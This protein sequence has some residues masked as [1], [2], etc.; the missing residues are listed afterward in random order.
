MAEAPK[1]AKRLVPSPKPNLSSLGG[2]SDF[3]D[4]L[5]IDACVEMVRRILTGVPSLPSG[6]ACSRV[7]LNIVVVFVAEY[8][9]TAILERRRL[10]W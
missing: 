9:S 5:P 6:P 3:L 4:A 1:E 7:I 2:N 8:G 10:S